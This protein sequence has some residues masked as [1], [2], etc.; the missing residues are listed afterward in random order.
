VAWAKQRAHEELERSGYVQAMASM[1][2]DL[3]KHEETGN[4]M[5]E[6]VLSALRVHDRASCARWIDE[7]N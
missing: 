6:P 4:A 2:S 1:L 3:Q 7:I 5:T